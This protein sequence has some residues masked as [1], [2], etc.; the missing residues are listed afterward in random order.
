[1]YIAGRDGD[2][3]NRFLRPPLLETKPA[4]QEEW[5]LLK[6]WKEKRKEKK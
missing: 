1:M 6:K 2:D 5:S 3:Q 4:A